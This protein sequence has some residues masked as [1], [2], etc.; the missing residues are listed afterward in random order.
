MGN[1]STDVTDYDS[2]YCECDEEKAAAMMNDTVDELFTSLLHK[3]GLYHP[4]AVIVPSLKITTNISSA[5]NNA[6][7]TQIPILRRAYQYAHA[8]HHGQC[9]KSGESYI[10]HPLGVVHIIADMK[11]DLPSLLTA[12]LHDTVEDA[13]VT[14]DDIEN[15]FSEEIKMLVDGVT[16]VGK[17]HLATKTTSY[18]E[19]QS[20]NYRKLIL[21]MSKDIRVLLVKL[22]DWAH[23]MSTLQYM[24]PEKQRR[25]AKET[26]EI[27][28]PLAHRLGIHWLKTELE[29]NS[30]KYLLP[31]KYERLDELVKGSEVERKRYEEDVVDMLVTQ[32]K[33]AGVGISSVS[34]KNGTTLSVTGRT[35]GLYYIHTKMRRNDLDFDDIHDVIAFRIIV[36]DVASCYQAL[37]VVHSHYKPVPGKIKDYIAVSIVSDL[38]IMSLHHQVVSHD[39]TFIYL[40]HFVSSSSSPNPTDIDHRI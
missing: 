33:E 9:R 6:T 31:K 32:M 24:H 15:L 3:V 19:Q 17:V 11:L 18:E 5:T 27:Y 25:I 16:K 7:A 23:N 29:D 30:F 34:S 35:K 36:D 39:D 20:E 38:H 1:N 21:S 2:L 40:L 14:L 4:E 22:V 8:A 12:L 26:L 37:G 28:A 10:T 13:E